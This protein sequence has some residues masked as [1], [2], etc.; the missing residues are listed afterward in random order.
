MAREEAVERA[1]TRLRALF[2]DRSFLYMTAV[3][4]AL[5]G[6]M[7]QQAGCAVGD[8]RDGRV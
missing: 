4:H 1:T 8:D 3:Y 2:R 7:A 6:L 5:G